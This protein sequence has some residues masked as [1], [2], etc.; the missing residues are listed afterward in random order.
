M[1]NKLNGP[2][3]REDRG[4]EIVQQIAMRR[5]TDVPT[6]EI[7]FDQDYRNS[8]RAIA[9]GRFLTEADIDKRREE[10]RRMDSGEVEISPTVVPV[11]EK[12][13]AGM[14][15]RFRAAMKKVFNKVFWL[16]KILSKTNSRTEFPKGSQS[17]ARLSGRA[18]LA[19]AN[20]GSYPLERG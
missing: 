20:S 14:I 7:D 2:A 3:D 12:E 16:S 9:E 18:G 4:R 8:L 1:S 15:G 11:Q 19:I 10:I 6:D 5:L 13:Q 17:A